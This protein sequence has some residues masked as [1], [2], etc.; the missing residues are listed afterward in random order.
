MLK[1]DSTS[2]VFLT[3]EL[4]STYLQ[5]VKVIFADL[6]VEA[7]HGDGVLRH[8]DPNVD[9]YVIFGAGQRVLKS[10]ALRFQMRKDLYCP[11]GPAN[12]TN[13]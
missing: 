13:L 3:D 8:L 2:L 1:I 11:Y 12:Q 4:D 10:A 5:G 7:S 9:N 6:G